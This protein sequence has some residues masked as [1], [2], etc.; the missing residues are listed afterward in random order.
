MTDWKYE[1]QRPLEHDYWA[2]A[3]GLTAHFVIDLGCEKTLIK[4]EIRNIQNGSV[5]GEYIRNQLDYH[6]N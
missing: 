3:V 6:S 2:G 5:M 4:I 1:G